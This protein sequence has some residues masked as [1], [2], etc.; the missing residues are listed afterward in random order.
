MTVRYRGCHVRTRY[1]F[2]IN[3]VIKYE[4]YRCP[5]SAYVC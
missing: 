2:E 1:A 5:G 3:P 4:S